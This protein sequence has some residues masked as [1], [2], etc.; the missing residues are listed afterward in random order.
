MIDLVLA[1]RDN[2]RSNSSF[3]WGSLHFPAYYL[4]P[5]SLKLS[6]KLAKCS[7]ISESTPANFEWFNCHTRHSFWPNCKQEL[8]R[9]HIGSGKSWNFMA[10]SR[11]GKSWNVLETCETLVEN[12]KWMQAV[13]IIKGL[14]ISLLRW[15]G[16]VISGRQVFFLATWWAG[17]FFPSYMLC[18]IFFSIV[19]LQDFFFLKKVS[20]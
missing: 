4:S 14:T 12:M 11:T 15:G 6:C 5:N 13:R 16:W 17:Y 19:S 3:L 10:F 20:C 18:R 8:H 2:S 9:V 7:D 1:Q